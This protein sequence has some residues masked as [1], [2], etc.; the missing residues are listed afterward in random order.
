MREFNIAEFVAFLGGAA[1]E[2]DHA[3]REALEKAAAVIED[4]AKRV[5]VNM[6]YNWPRL[7]RRRKPNASAKRWR[8]QSLLSMGLHIRQ[9]VVEIADGIYD[10]LIRSVV[11]STLEAKP[12]VYS[13]VLPRDF[14]APS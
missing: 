4:E 3:Q 7:P 1:V 13:M 9:S 10:L 5:S 14:S 2:I 6:H 11:R 8:R 12:S